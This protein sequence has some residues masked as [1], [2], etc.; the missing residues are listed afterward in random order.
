MSILLLPMVH[1]LLA[2]H[3]VHE[4]THGSLSS[5][6]GIN[7][8]CQFTSHPILF[9]VHVWIPQ[10]LLSHHQYT[11]DPQHDV[12][13]H[14]FAPARLAQSQPPYQPTTTTTSS[15][16]TTSSS[17][18]W[19]QGWTF[20]LKGCLTTLGTCILQPLRT[21]LDQNTPNFHVNITPVP[22]MAVCKRTLLLSMM[23]SLF[24]LLYPLTCLAMG[25]FSLPQA[26]WAFIWP[27]VG[28]S[29]IWTVMTQTSH[30]Q[31]ACQWSDK[32]NSSSSSLSSSSSCWT[33]QQVHTA[34]DYSVHNSIVTWATAGLNHQGLHHALPA[35]S[36]SHFNEIRH[37]Y[38]VI[39]QR[40][41]VQPR[42]VSNLA[43]AC[44]S[45][46][47]Y[48]FTLNRPQSNQIK[49]TQSSKPTQSTQSTQSTN[50]RLVGSSD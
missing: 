2:A 29:I 33:T 44:Q 3:T 6:S 26:L 9:N 30:I 32:D 49:P 46:L 21:L 19:N 50:Q 42:Q 45:C 47:N 25:L 14:H 41:G 17:S 10:H 7:Y 31:E 1:W 24:V 37:D 13:V 8:W 18:S 4:A 11:N 5:H 22:A 15:L 12:D 16:T 36:C 27:W 35:V 23:P 20:V 40:H 38:E 43:I 48:V 39:C 34:M 28:M